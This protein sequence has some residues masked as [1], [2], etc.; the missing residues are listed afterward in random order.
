MK[1]VVGLGNPGAQYAAT[2]HNIG[3]LVADA[4]SSAHGIRL[5]PMGGH[6][7]AGQGALAGDALWVAEPQ[8]YMNRSGIAVQW[9]LA[10]SGAGPESLL[11][12]HDDLDL[13]LGQVRLKRRGGHGG[14]NGVRSI[15]ETLGTDEFLRLKVG[16]GR[17][18][19]GRDTVD[20]VLEPFSREEKAA[21]AAVVERSREAV[22]VVLT[23]GV[24]AAMNRFHASAA[25]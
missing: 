16:I 2:R 21:V 13:P 17:P 15:I 23:E 18:P 20:Y 3:F 14:H 19:T 25:E 10:E 4:V 9:L 11:V 12:V 7:L 22:T 5:R 8:G 1:C 24:G 6:V